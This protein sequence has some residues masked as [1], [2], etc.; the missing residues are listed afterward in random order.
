MRKLMIAIG[1]IASIAVPAFASASPAFA[2]PRDDVFN[3]DRAVNGS[4]ASTPGH[5]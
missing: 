5:N 2:G 3:Y 1:L 4:D